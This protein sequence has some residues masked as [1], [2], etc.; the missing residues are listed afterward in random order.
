MIFFVL[1]SNPR[2]NI[3]LV[4]S[5]SLSDANKQL[6]ERPLG[7]TT[8]DPIESTTMAGSTTRKLTEPW[9]ID[10]RLPDDTLPQHYEIFLHPDLSAGN[11]TG[12]VD[13]HLNITK[14]RDFILV[15]TKYLVVTSIKL[16]KGRQPNGEEIAISENF[17]YPPNEFWVVKLSQKIPP[18][19]YVLSMKF[20]GSL[21]LDIV[22]FYKS[23]YFNSE[24]NSTR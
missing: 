8:L 16:S 9:E 19:E 14:A 21:T 12:S 4:L 10:Y 11:F 2:D 22:G 5:V 23:E 6:S 1:S 24:I 17:E 20:S 7:D 15:H 13:I 3:Q 18:G